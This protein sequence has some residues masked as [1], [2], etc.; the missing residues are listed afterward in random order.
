MEFSAAAR[1][2]VKFCN[3]FLRISARGRNSRFSSRK[4]R[5][6][7]YDARDPT[8]NGQ[9]HNCGRA[10]APGK[11]RVLTMAWAEPVVILADQVLECRIRQGQ[12]HILRKPPVE[13]DADHLPTGFVG[14][15]SNA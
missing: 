14:A 2:P 11:I 1:A 3:A 7:N 10:R 13:E 8:E 6:G 4:I 9:V 12:V 15:E 5:R